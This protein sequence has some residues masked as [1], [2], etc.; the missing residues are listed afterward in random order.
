MPW[1]FI[2]VALVAAGLLVGVAWYFLIRKAS[3]PALL[4]DI[5]DARKRKRGVPTGGKVSVVVTNIEGYSGER[6]R[7]MSS[8]HSLL[9]NM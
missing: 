4:Q 2:F 3:R 6:G 5:L 7:S 8:M 1:I 9:S